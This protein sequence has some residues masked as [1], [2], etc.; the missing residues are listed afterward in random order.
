MA[1]ACDTAEHDDRRAER[2]PIL[3]PARVRTRS[4]FLDRVMVTDI[5][6]WGCRIESGAL[7]MH[8]GDLVVVR[9]EGVEGLCGRICWVDGHTAGIEFDRPLYGPVVEHLRREHWHFLADVAPVRGAQLRLA[10]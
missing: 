9:P 10:A 6:I 5:S 7:T 2:F 4:G 3:L 8:K 1:Q